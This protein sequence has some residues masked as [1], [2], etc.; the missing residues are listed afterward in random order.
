M[1]EG[2]EVRI[3]G[4]AHVNT[5]LPPGAT[6]P[7]GWVAVGDPA[8]I[9][10]P[11]QHQ[12]IGEIQESLDFPGTVY[13][14]TPDTPASERMSRQAAWFAAHRRDRILDEGS[15]GQ[16]DWGVQASDAQQ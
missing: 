7:I 13:G 8:E 6:V 2:S 3:H 16:N 14:V 5:V 10:S 1:E 4:V 12:H 11:A 15:P 9:Y